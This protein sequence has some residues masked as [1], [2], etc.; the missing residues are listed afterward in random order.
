[1]FRRAFRQYRKDPA[2]CAE[3]GNSVLSDLIYGWGNDEWSAQDEYLV[4][5][6]QH[7]LTTHGSILECGSGLSTVL[8]GSIATQRGIPYSAL[9][10]TPAWAVR[11]LSEIKR[12]DISAVTLFSCPI[13]GHGDF[14]WYDFPQGTGPA[15]I[16]LVI[17]DGPPGDT[18]GGRYGLV[19]VMQFNLQP[20]CVILLDDAARDDER[21]VAMRWASE[22]GAAYEVLGDR[23]PYAR[24]ITPKAHK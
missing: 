22:M 17:C 7:A 19:P 14:D 13:I 18:R 8:I 1:M 2:A 20:E 24:L 3:V 23:K 10:H 21:R 15:S 6:I 5:C 9:E 16:S 11:V 12:Y 4:A